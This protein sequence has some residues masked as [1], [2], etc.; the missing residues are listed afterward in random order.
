MYVGCGTVVAIHLISALYVIGINR[1]Q[2]GQCLEAGYQ[3]TLIKQSL[4]QIE[5]LL[6]IFPFKI[7]STG[8]GT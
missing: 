8:V 3:D 7:V 1:K 5:Q 2:L 4:T 6:L